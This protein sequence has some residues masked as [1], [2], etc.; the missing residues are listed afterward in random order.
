[1][2]FSLC[3][4]GAGLALFLWGMELLCAGLKQLSGGRL[5]TFI[6][7]SAHTAP[8]FLSGLAGAVLLQSSSA[9]V[10]MAVGL[11]DSGLLALPQAAAFIM[12]ANLGTTLTPWLLLPGV[13]SGP[14]VAMP[15][16]LGLLFR[17]H[18]AGKA[19][20]GL[21][22]L[23]TGMSAMTAALAPLGRSPRAAA[24]LAVC[25]PATGLAAGLFLTGVMQ[26]S[27]AG[28][29]MLAALSRGG[30]L[31]LGRA[32][33][34]LMGFNIGTCS[35]ALLASIRGG[36]TARR[37]AVIHLYFNLGGTAVGLLLLPAAAELAPEFLSRSITPAG[38]ALAHT[39]FNLL[40]AA[41]W[42]PFTG[43]LARFAILTIPAKKQKNNKSSTI[44]Q[45]ISL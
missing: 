22:L 16:G 31:P 36:V 45:K 4:L 7:Q 9:A 41:L 42:L 5:R 13:F 20:A 33:P 6:G 3:G 15:L 24:L 21:S 35:T 2:L 38:I 28:V 8:T 43:P 23:L 17:H 29:A 30:G 19:L 18:P 10:V 14:L 37:A 12:G 32:L 44:P 25:T 34:I 11:A 27:A 40:A 39:A 1:M 26:S